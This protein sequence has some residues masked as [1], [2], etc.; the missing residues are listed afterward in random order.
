YDVEANFA[1]TLAAIRAVHPNPAAIVVTGDLADLGEPD[2]Y[3]RL[4]AAVEPVA[5]E[6]GAPVIWVAGN[7]DERPAL[8]R[9]LLDL[10]PTE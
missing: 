4:R 8:R 10:A 6:L 5:A 1:R 9:D 7:H 2:A 3:R